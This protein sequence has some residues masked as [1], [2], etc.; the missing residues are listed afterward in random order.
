MREDKNERKTTNTAAPNLSECKWSQD[1]KTSEAKLIRKK[2]TINESIIITE[3]IKVASGDL[4]YTNGF[5][6]PQIIPKK[7][8]KSFFSMM[9]IVFSILE[10]VES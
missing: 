3:N 5:G 8:V 7:I 4:D 2:E 9:Y 1:V 6:F 10:S